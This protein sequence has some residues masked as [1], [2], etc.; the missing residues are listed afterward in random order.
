ML[1]PPH[2]AQLI[3]EVLARGGPFPMDAEA[4][5]HDAIALV[6]DIGGV[7]MLRDDGTFWES[8]ADSGKPLTPLP[9]EHQILVLVYGTKRFPWL[10]EL[11]PK[12]PLNSADC[13]SCSGD[14]MLYPIG[15][16][17]GYCCHNCNGLGWRK[18]HGNSD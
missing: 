8:D 18:T 17:K 7:M 13:V 16:V 5:G 11:L 9:E 10:A 6:G 3:R 1:I 12:R 2:I 15:N 14:G 4:Q